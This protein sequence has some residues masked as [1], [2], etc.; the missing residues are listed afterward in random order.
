MSWIDE[1]APVYEKE[2]AEKEKAFDRLARRRSHKKARALRMAQWDK[3]N[4]VER[5]PD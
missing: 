5:N 4:A 3:P 2:Q 1:Y